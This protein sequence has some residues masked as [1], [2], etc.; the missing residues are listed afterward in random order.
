MEKIVKK[1]LVSGIK[2]LLVVGTIAAASFLSISAHAGMPEETMLKMGN[3][4]A[5]ST[6]I[7]MKLHSLEN[8]SQGPAAALAAPA[9]NVVMTQ[10]T[11]QPK[12]T[13]RLNAQTAENFLVSVPDSPLMTVPYHGS[14]LRISA[15][16]ANL[17]DGKE[18]IFLISGNSVRAS[19]SMLPLFNILADFGFCVVTYNMPGTGI[20]Q[21]FTDGSFY[22]PSFQAQVINDVMTHFDLTETFIFAWSLGG[23]YTIDG[24]RNNDI[25]TSRIKGIFF[26]DVQ[27]LNLDPALPPTDL[28][29]TCGANAGATYFLRDGLSPV[30]AAEIGLPADDLL[31]TPLNFTE[32]AELFAS[33]FADCDPSSRAVKFLFPNSND[34][35]D[36]FRSGIARG[37]F[38]VG[39]RVFN[40]DQIGTIRDIIGGAGIFVGIG[41]GVQEELLDPF[42]F[43]RALIAAGYV[44]TFVPN[45]LTS[46]IYLYSQGHSSL[47]T[48]PFEVA[49]AIRGFVASVNQQQ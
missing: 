41:F 17:T 2:Q 40:L 32:R 35:R 38:G 23:S 42:V 13:R 7:T 37:V 27:L 1:S 10:N 8:W 48:A 33:L 47:Y 20:T 43:P 9:T 19:D 18:C 34:T 16:T 5:P 36:G 24:I 15:W 11:A 21:S 4:N 39:D 49:T 31:A 45:P 3:A 28:A 22:L 25:D 26:N 30:V 12:I 14:Q 6:E 44:P 46:S 29:G